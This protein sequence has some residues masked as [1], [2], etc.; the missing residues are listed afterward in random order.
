MQRR[1]FVATALATSAGL[2]RT[3]APAAAALSAKRW[4]LVIIGAGTAGLPAAIFASRRGA[5]VLLLDSAN[6]I[7]GN[8]HLANGQISAAGSR[9]QAAKGIVDSPDRHF[10]D[11]MRITRG[12]ADPDITRLTVDRAPR[13][14]NWL[15]DNGLKPL[16]EHPLTGDAPGRPGYSIPRY[17]WGKNEGRDILAVIERELAP[18][19]GQRLRYN[20]VEFQSC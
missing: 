10:D 7:G 3:S 15:L 1:D 12:L 20:P 6:K 2:V 17:I 11:V 5:R 13:T 9:T 4:D 14:I 18:E 16:P 19:A 8:L